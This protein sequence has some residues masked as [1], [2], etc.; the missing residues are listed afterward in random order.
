MAQ[1][2]DFVLLNESLGM[3]NAELLDAT[4]SVSKLGKTERL[5]QRT[6]SDLLKK[7]KGRFKNKS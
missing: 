5:Q 1:L 4:K 7:L 2:H 3:D 6:E